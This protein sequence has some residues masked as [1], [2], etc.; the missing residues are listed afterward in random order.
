M[1]AL[2]NPNSYFFNWYAVPPVIV[3]TLILAIG[4]FVLFQNRVSPTHRSFFLWCVTLNLWLYGMGLVYSSK[5]GDH[6]LSIYRW[7][8]FLGVSHIAPAVYTFSAHWLGF[9]QKQKRFVWLSFVVAPFFYLIAVTTPY[10]MPYIQTYFWGYYPKYGIGGMLFL[11]FFFGYFL[12]AFFNFFHGLT[13]QT[14]PLRKKQVQMIALAYTVCFAASADYLP[15]LIVLNMYPIGF[16]WVFLWTSIAAYSIV[17][18]KV[19][20][21][22]TVIHQ[23]ILWLVTSSIAILPIFGIFY[24]LK[25]WYHHISE[26]A[27][28]LFISVLFFAFFFYLKTVQPRVDHWF[29]RREHDLQQTLI[30]FN[31]ALVHLK[32]LT[33]LSNYIVETIR[34]VLYVDRVQVFLKHSGGTSLIQVD[35]EADGAVE[36]SCE[37]KFIRW[38][39]EKDNVALAEYIEIDPWL[40]P[41]KDEA[42]RFFQN[43]EIQVVVPLVLN[44][45]LIGL[46][47]LGRK[48][49]LKSFRAPEISFL[50]ELRRAAT[51]ALSNSLRL[52]DMQESLR[53]WNEELEEKVRQRTF[54]LEEAQRQLIQAEKLAT[55]GTLAGGVAHE[56]NNPLTAVLTNAQ[57]LKMDAKDIDLESLN[58]IE[59]GAKRC[60]EIIQKI[61]KYARKPEVEAVMEKVSL[62]NVV[63]NAVSFLEY[64]LK[65]ENIEVIVKNSKTVPYANANN[66]ELAQVLTNLILN[67][68]DAIRETQRA[69]KIE[70]EILALNGVVGFKVKDNGHGIPEQNLTKIFDPFFT[71][72]DVGKG[73][74]LGL[75]VT[76][77]IVKKYGGRIDVE[78]KSNLGTVFTIMFPKA[79]N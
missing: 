7:I 1:L 69:G 56:I 66:N 29:K 68:K 49:N 34:N 13:I 39:E 42:K 10:G 19:M 26:G 45:E 46:I 17:K 74:G 30:K 59:E 31:N 27:F 37:N 36:P 21:I 51:I 73:T 58:L 40:E 24:V 25:G 70:I 20:N 77:G 47:N 28:A 33:E 22:E 79:F 55:I 38:L 76:Y 4:L 63:E 71:T 62:N 72:K 53:K 43:L 16:L 48:A 41:V 52:I 57:L 54:E 35:A 60:R 50:S 18:Y 44:H 65:Q 14:D 2:V 15:K 67:A 75:A 32:D 9:Y 8:V 12:G 3:S 11:L 23:T 5:F 64:Q 61:M 6:A 78:S